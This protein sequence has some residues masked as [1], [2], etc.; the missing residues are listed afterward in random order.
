MHLKKGERPAAERCI[1]DFGEEKTRTKQSFADECNIN[2]IMKQYERTGLITHENSMHPVYGDFSNVDDY[3]TSM[4]KVIAAQDDFD[5]LSARVRK[6]FGH[7]PAEL[8]EFMAD[9]KNLDEAISLGLVPKPKGYRTP[10]PSA[11]PAQAAAGDS[12]PK[13]DIPVPP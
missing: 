4:N 2:K 11:E 5:N 9:E 10:S 1:L 7:D 3:Q 13:G 12:P 6:R 8:I